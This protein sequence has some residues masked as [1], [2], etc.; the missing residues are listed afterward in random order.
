MGLVEKHLGKI[1]HSLHDIEENL[2]LCQRAEE[3]AIAAMDDRKRRKMVEKVLKR[4]ED[5][6]GACEYYSSIV[7]DQDLDRALGM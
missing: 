4:A 7:N 6:L 2:Q 3:R 1:T 5:L